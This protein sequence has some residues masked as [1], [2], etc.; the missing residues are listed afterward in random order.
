M[1][2]SGSGM[3][4]IRQGKWK[5]TLGRGSGGFSVPKSIKPKPGEPKGQ[6][7]NLENDLA[8]SRNL[9]SENPEIVER[10]TNLLQKYK[11]QGHS[12]PI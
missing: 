12:R 1:H 5:L 10:L 6:L 8:E 7:Y 11:Q 4:A 3:F 2:H 9:W